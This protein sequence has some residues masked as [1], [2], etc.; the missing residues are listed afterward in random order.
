MGSSL[1]RRIRVIILH[2]PKSRSAA[3]GLPGMPVYSGQ[4]LAFSDLAFFR[5]VA[6]FT[7]VVNNIFDK[8][9]KHYH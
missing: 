9:T 3:A 7:S 2:L 4:Q 5:I 1:Y 6:V 8:N